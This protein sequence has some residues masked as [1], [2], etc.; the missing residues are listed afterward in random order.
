MQKL[1]FV[2]RSQQWGI[3]EVQEGLNQRIILSPIQP[4]AVKGTE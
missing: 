1:D 2:M 4:L 3:T